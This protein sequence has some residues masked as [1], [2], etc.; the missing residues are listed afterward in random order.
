MAASHPDR[1]DQMLEVLVPPLDASRFSVAVAPASA[2]CAIASALRP[3][4]TT[5]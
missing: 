5:C 2:K 1:I 3:S 4:L